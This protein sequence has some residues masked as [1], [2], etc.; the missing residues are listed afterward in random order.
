MKKTLLHDLKNLD[1]YLSH[2]LNN[3]VLEITKTEQIILFVIKTF[4]NNDANKNL[5]K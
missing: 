4:Q 3:K 2:I 1:N 5:Q